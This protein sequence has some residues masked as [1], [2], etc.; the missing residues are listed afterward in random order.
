MIQ[1]TS[2]YI[3]SVEKGIPMLLSPLYVEG[4]PPVDFADRI[5]ASIPNAVMN[6]LH[7]RVTVA[8]ADADKDLLDGLH[9]V[10]FKTNF[11]EMGAGFLGL[12]WL[13]GGGYYLGKSDEHTPRQRIPF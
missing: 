4:G 3:M 8:I 5:N 12:A 11:G 6:E 13:R 7:K 9:S 10:G 2:T 1:R